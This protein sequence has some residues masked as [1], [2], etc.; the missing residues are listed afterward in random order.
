MTLQGK[1]ACADALRGADRVLIVAHVNPD[2]DALGSSLALAEGLKALGKRPGI[3]VDGPVP[4]TF[5]FL[6]LSGLRVGLEEG[7]WDTGVVLDCPSLDRT[8]PAAA[9]LAG[10]P[11][12]VNIDHHPGN[13][14]FAH[15][16]WAE[17]AAAATGELVH[18][19]LVALGAPIGP[20]AALGLYAA[21]ADDTGGFRYSNTTSATLRLAADLVDLG[22]RP[23]EVAQSL[24]DRW[25]P[26]GLRLL[27]AALARIETLA[28]GAA[29]L[30][31]L[32]R[33]L[34]AACGASDEDA[35][36]VINYLRGLEGVRVA[37]VLREA[38][39]GKQRLSL[40]SFGAVNVSALAGQFGGGGHACAAGATLPDGLDEAAE[41]VR[42][43]LEEACRASGA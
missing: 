40:R 16:A 15:A 42:R 5:S 43:A 13:A 2:A 1:Q 33:G 35:D 10:C 24:F 18:G 29:A 36:P 21:L 7:G 11:T 9:A 37:A 39:P 19:V 30:A 4:S 12:L 26:Q 6:P 31:V 23:A 32:D 25:T 22:V 41:R 28:G 8:G 27:G 20:A 34:F 3:Y 38:A 17:P 14:G